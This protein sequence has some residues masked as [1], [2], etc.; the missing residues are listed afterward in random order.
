[1]LQQNPQTFLIQFRIAAIHFHLLGEGCADCYF[2]DS[3]VHESYYRCISIH[4]TNGISVSENVAYDVTGFCYYLEDGVEERN[5]LSFNLA[6]HVHFI[7]NPA[8]GG[9]Q[10]I[11]VVKESP[12]LLLPADVA[13]SG[14]YIT[15][16]HNFIIGNVAVGG[17]AGFAF[18]ILDKPVG[19]HKDDKF[20]PKTKVSLIIDGNTAH[21]TAHFWGSAA[22]FYFGG[23]LYF[24][25]NDL[26][27]YNA[28]R[29]ND[30]SQRRDPCEEDV[31]TGECISTENHLTNS[32]VFLVGNVGV[33]SWSGKMDVEK[34]EAHDVGLALEALVSGF[35]IDQMT[36]VCRTGELL[37]LPVQRANEIQGN[38]FVWYVDDKI[39]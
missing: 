35:W 17:W 33:G 22:A 10:R 24:N 9:G 12:D 39:V 23:S 31:E 38:G 27:E 6:A 19:L 3:S 11:A 8:L 18:P 21:S 15:N 20:S 1:M 16:L 4:G 2:R 36:V 28:G 32:K 14:F 29:D 37:K 5:T 26:L 13:A 25:S 34:Y 30:G 7:G